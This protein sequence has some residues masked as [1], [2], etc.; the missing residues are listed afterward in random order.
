[1][2]AIIVEFL[3]QYVVICIQYGEQVEFIQVVGTVGEEIILVYD[4]IFADHIIIRISNVG[5]FFCECGQV[6]HRHQ[7]HV[8]CHIRL[9]YHGVILPVGEHAAHAK[10][11][12]DIKKR[13]HDNK[14]DSHSHGHAG[15]NRTACFL[16][17][18]S[19]YHRTT[20]EA[21]INSTL[22]VNP[23]IEYSTNDFGCKIK[24]IQIGIVLNIPAD[25]GQIGA[26]SVLWRHNKNVA[27]RFTLWWID[28]IIMQFG[29][30]GVL[31]QAGEVNYAS[32]GKLDGVYICI[33]P[34]YWLHRLHTNRMNILYAL[35]A[36]LDSARDSDG[37]SL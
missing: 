37:E 1:M 14:A 7:K 26:A 2:V 34:D 12:N 9:V 25:E 29:E 36:Q 6:F 24:L 13:K 4:I 11:K 33:V 30:G 10:G 16:I 8:A 19:A 27:K 17:L 3:E 21:R 32:M 18:F 15:T 20:P 28:D 22:A 35:I 23:I 5:P 31:L